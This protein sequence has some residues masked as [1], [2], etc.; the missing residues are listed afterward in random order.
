LG[1]GCPSDLA[2]YPSQQ[3]AN[4]QERKQRPPDQ[5]GAERHPRDAE[6]SPNTQEAGH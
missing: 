1:L 5:R 3:T 4:A 2:A 6:R